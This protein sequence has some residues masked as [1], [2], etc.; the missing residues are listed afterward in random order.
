MDAFFR[1]PPGSPLAAAVAEDWGLLP[2]R[3]PTGW[4]VVYNEL[5]ARLLPDGSVEVNDS[6]DLYWARTAL[7][8]REVGIDAGWYGGHGFRLVVLD[9][10]WEHERASRTTRDLG[11]LVATLEAWMEA[12]AHGRLPEPDLAP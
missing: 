8:D 9:P 2:L 3:V 6:E 4:T 1:L 5:S 10:D 11:E 7:Q 12:I